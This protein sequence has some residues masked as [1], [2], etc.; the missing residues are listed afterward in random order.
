MRL[1][2]G[3]PDLSEYADRFEVPAATDDSDLQVTFLGVS[4]LLIRDGDSAVLT[5]GFFSRPGLARVALGRVAPDDVRIDAALA[6]AGLTGVGSLDLVTPVHSHYDHALDSAAVAARTGALLAGGTS[7]ANIGLGGGLAEESLLRV[8]SGD[9]H[10]VGSFSLTWIASTHCPP[11]RFPG[12]IT[13]PLTPPARVRAYKCGEA[14]SIHVEHDSGRSCLIQGSAGF[15]PGAL[16]GLHAPVVYLGV[17]QLGLHDE[18]YLRAYWDETV[19]TLGARRVVL[20]HWDDFFSPLTRPLR[21]VPYA[22]DDLDATWRVLAPLA[23]A[24]G[25]DLQFPTLWRAEDPW[26]GLAGL[27]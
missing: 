15:V 4:S 24:Q 1:R 27:D 11:D 3:R 17:G 12:E 23:K 2:W 20:I 22:G 9:S 19:V 8:A 26:Q 6:Q 18:E 21:A 13:E 7:T 16:I 10:R 14:W 5:D 25:V